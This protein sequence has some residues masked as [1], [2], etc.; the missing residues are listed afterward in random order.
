MDEIQLKDLLRRADRAAGAPPTGPRDLADRVRQLHVRRRLLVVKVGGA[1]AA[2]VAV[3]IGVSV[4]VAK[5]P[6][7]PVRDDRPLNGTKVTESGC[8]TWAE[9]DEV[10]KQIAELR[11]EADA[12]LAMVKH[13]TALQEQEDRLTELRRTSGGLDP[14]E[15]VR[16]QVE[17]AA[18][19][20]LYQADRMYRELNL[21]EAALESYRQ[22]ISLFPDTP[23]AQIAQQR[24]SEIE[25]SKGER[26]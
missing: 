2:L 6:V 22:V 4:L 13:L 16:Q 14:L 11:A 15:D 25:S 12:V 26:L 18:F 5:H 9:L 21:R 10:R 24:L 3:G 1:M 8:K 17:K 7:Q 20:T 19:I 23:S